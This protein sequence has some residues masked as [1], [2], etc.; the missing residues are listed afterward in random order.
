MKFTYDLN[1]APASWD[2]AA[3]LASAVMH[4]GMLNESVEVHLKPGLH[5]GFRNDG[6]PLSISE[7]QAMLD[8]VVRPLIGL[9]GARE[10]N[11]SGGY[12][13]T[14]LMH[15]CM[16]L[17]RLGAKRPDF[18]AGL[19]TGKGYITITTR[20][21]DY[22]LMRNANMSA[23]EKLAA[24]LEN[25]GE[26]I[27]W[28]RDTA[29]GGPANAIERARIYAGAKLNLLASNGPGMLL[30][31]SDAPYLMF[32]PITEAPA[33]SAEWW[34]NQVGVPK[35]TQFPWANVD[36][37]IVWEP[38]EFETMWRAWNELQDMRA[39]A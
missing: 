4:A 10:T 5:H 37:R 31:M 20:E 33:T 22:W 36:Q 21:T 39:A 25:A 13:H 11:E 3:W 2:F 23:W 28:V 35:D 8:N 27:V 1:A 7:R 18:L 12:K 6:L 14:Y 26:T 9:A 29:K 15:H 34:A 19:S 16:R 38:D 24:K 17:Y 30:Y 32:K